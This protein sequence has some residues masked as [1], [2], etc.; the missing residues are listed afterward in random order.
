L[1]LDLIDDYF[2]FSDLFP[3]STPIYSD[4]SFSYKGREYVIGQSS[5]GL[6]IFHFYTSYF[7][8]TS[9]FVFD[10][11]S[12][13]SVFGSLREFNVDGG[14]YYSPSLLGKALRFYLDQVYK[15]KSGSP[16][17][18]GVPSVPPGDEPLAKKF[19]QLYGAGNIPINKWYVSPNLFFGFLVSSVGEN[20]F[21]VAHVFF[22]SDLE[23]SQV[24]DFSEK[25]FTNGSSEH[26]PR[27]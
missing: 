2:T 10:V 27:A 22:S 26:G 12:M 4:G 9:T 5:N 19:A 3:G 16:D 20:S 7:P 15:P 21:C 17:P 23:V 18:K 24:V 8:K 14:S 6:Y 1:R 25:V 13:Q 11:G